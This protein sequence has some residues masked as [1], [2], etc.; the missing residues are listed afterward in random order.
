MLHP[1]RQHSTDESGFTL[2]ELLVVIL[3]IGILAAIAIP[4]LLS[5]KNKAYD[6][7]AKTLAGSAQTAAETIAT[8]NG[9]SYASV[10]EKEINKYEK[11]IPITEA[12][13]NGGAWLEK[14]ES[15]EAGEGYKIKVI[16]PNTKDVFELT[17]NKEG[18]VKRKCTE[19]K[20][21]DHGCTKGT[22]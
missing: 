15:T 10:T 16:A 2:I 14:A 21:E 9:G 22:W 20:V 6:A 7:S 5:Q 17:K 12:T 19:V 4:S 3:I 18:E 11:N 1:L 8:D 13:A